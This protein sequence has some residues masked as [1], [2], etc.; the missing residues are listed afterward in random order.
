M[1]RHEQINFGARNKSEY[2][3]KTECG[4]CHAQ[5][6]CR[7]LKPGTLMP[8]FPATYICMDCDR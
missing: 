3:I 7:L 8:R 5:K 6:K 2:T 1:M 4:T